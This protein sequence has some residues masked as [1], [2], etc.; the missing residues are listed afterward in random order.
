[1]TRVVLILGLV[2]I[3]GCD[4]GT[5][6]A[7][8]PTTEPTASSTEHF[9][10]VTPGRALAFPVVAQAPRPTGPLP[11]GASCMTAE[12]HADY[13]R[14]P[15]IHSPVAQLACD[16][17][18]AGDV[19]GH[20]FP[21]KR[22]ANQTCTFCHSVSNTESFQHKALEQGC[23]SC[24]QPH[25]SRAKFLLKADTVERTCATCHE[26]PLQKFAHE[27]FL[28]GQCTVCHQ[29]HQADNK[30]L[31]RVSGGSKHC[32]T[33]H[34]ELGT[35]MTAATFVHKPAGQ[36]CNVC[37]NPHATA[38]PHQL[39]TPIDQNCLSCHDKIAKALKESN[40]QHSA[41]VTA[42]SCANCHNPHASDQPALLAHRMDQTC[43]T[44]HDKP[45]PATDGHTIPNMKPVLAS[46]FLHGPIRAGSCSGCHDPHGSKFPG[47]LDKAFPRTFY[48]SFDEAKYALCFTCH[49]SQLVL[50]EKAQGLTNFRDGEK[51][52]HFIHVNRDDKGRT[53]KTCHA[54]HGSNLPNHMATEVPFEGSNWAMPIEF[55]KKADGGSC[56]PGCHVPKTYTRDVPTTLPT[57][58]GV[59]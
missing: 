8:K 24:H 22:D 57:T 54:I 5:S 53:C 12:C 47:L 44:C 13:S 25:T 34:G 4:R 51:N 7:V 55:V 52:L 33:C 50:E 37:H 56:A 46:Q 21:L 28:K 27:P 10:N 36:D 30:A 2:S 20:K 32:F 26:M 19:G 38:F 16:S 6:E 42:D 49:N 31:L 48:T 9:T 39:K 40:I 3:L 29:P 59:P 58:R 14:A 18:H 45:L 43:L 17:C 41:M 35:A 11:A 15:Q 1:M 23:L